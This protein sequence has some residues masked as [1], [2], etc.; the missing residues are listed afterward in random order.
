MKHVYISSYIQSW[1]VETFRYECIK[2]FQFLI[3]NYKYKV[4]MIDKSS[5]STEFLVIFKNKIKDD[6]FVIYTIL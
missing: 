3:N 1:V 6:S 5:L 4:K 2:Y